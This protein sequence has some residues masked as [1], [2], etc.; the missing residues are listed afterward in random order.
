[1]VRGTAP[2]PQEGEN[3]NMSEGKSE[4]PKRE[5]LPCL[6]GSGNVLQNFF[7]ALGS[8]FA[9][10]P[11]SAEMK[12]RKFWD[13]SF[14]RDVPIHCFLCQRLKG[15]MKA[16]VLFGPFIKGENIYVIKKIVASERIF[17]LH[18]STAN[19]IVTR[20]DGSSDCPML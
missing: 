3:R 7:K 13:N 5:L 11:L 2:A 10:F 19:P 1:M 20:A 14:Y 4:P 15:L 6:S 9:A 8:Q 18:K 17:N 12:F 16:S